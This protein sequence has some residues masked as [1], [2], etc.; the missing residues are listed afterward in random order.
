MG[1]FYVTLPSNSNLTEFPDKQSNNFKVRLAE[2]LRLQGGGWSVGL[3]SVSLPDEKMNLFSLGYHRTP[4]QFNFRSVKGE[5]ALETFQF[6]PNEVLLKMDYHRYKATLSKEVS[7]NTLAL[8][9]GINTGRLLFD[10]ST[11]RQAFKLTSWNFI[12]TSTCTFHDVLQDESSIV[13]GVE[14]MRFIINSTLQSP[15][16]R[17]SSYNSLYDADG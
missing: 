16:K 9:T 3:S 6:D 5:D 10:T 7:K 8:G 2:P 15:L 14:F 4:I 12:S 17:L 11:N 13:D 1:D